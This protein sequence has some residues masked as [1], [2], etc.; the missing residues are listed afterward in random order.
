MF[1]VTIYF[2][3]L[4]PFL[5]NQIL[6]NLRLSKAF[7][8]EALYVT[9]KSLSTKAT[10][11]STS[12][13]AF[14]TAQSSLLKNSTTHGRSQSNMPPPWHR[15]CSQQASSCKTTQKLLTFTIWHQPNSI[16]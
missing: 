6:S 11:P 7:K 1:E 14:F 3:L 4:L 12:A 15:Q 13:T 10:F 9:V 16:F 5:S 8:H 2:P